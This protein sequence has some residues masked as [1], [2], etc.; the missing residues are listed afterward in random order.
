MFYVERN[1]GLSCWTK[2]STWNIESKE[3]TS[4]FHVEQS[5]ASSLKSEAMKDLL[6]SEHDASLCSV[7]LKD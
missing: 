2:C 7:V 6:A 1:R 4:M 5:L 3:L